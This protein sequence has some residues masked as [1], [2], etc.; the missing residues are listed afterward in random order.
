ME[1][2]ENNKPLFQGPQ[3]QQFENEGFRKVPI[4]E[5]DDVDDADGYMSTYYN[6]LNPD[7]KDPFLG[8]GAEDEE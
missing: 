2:K 4:D 6:L 3:S 1:S 7:Q 8:E 5:F